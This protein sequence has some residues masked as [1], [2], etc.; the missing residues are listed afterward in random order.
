VASAVPDDTIETQTGSKSLLVFLPLKMRAIGGSLLGLLSSQHYQTIAIR[1]KPF[2]EH[3]DLRTRIL[4]VAPSGWGS[5]GT[6]NK[7]CRPAEYRSFAASGNNAKA[8]RTKRTQ[9]CCLRHLAAD[10]GLRP[11][12]TRRRDALSRPWL[13]FN[14]RQPSSKS[15]PGI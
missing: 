1:T 2:S 14:P 7:E 3:L 8:E 10:G 15:W 13:L 11:T 5:Q 6:N 4:P 9:S 12:R